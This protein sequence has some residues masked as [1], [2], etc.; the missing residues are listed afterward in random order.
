MHVFRRS[1]RMQG[2]RRVLERF[3]TEAIGERPGSEDERVSRFDAL[4]PHVWQDIGLTTERGRLARRRAMNEVGEL[5]RLVAGEEEPRAANEEDLCGAD[6]RR[7]QLVV[8]DDRASA[9]ERDAPPVIPKPLRRAA[10]R[11]AQR[12]AQRDL[13]PGREVVVV[14]LAREIRDLLGDVGAGV[15][16]VLT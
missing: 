5:A 11:L 12:F 16:A 9:M 15:R 14:L 4:P 3:G 10:V 7:V 8:H 13:D 1:A 2:H 6:A